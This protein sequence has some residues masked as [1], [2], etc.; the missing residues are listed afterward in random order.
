ML[1]RLVCSRRRLIGSWFSIWLSCPRH[2]CFLAIL[3]ICPWDSL[4][5]SYRITQTSAGSR[6]A[7]ISQNTHCKG[8]YSSSPSCNSHPIH[9]FVISASMKSYSSD[10]SIQNY[11][12][13]T[14]GSV[15]SPLCSF[16]SRSLYPNRQSPLVSSFTQLILPR[17]CCSRS[18][19]PEKT[20]IDRAA[21]IICLFSTAVLSTNSLTTPT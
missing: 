9:S 6:F 18:T 21:S 19:P 16:S 12:S 3:Y 7:M 14:G 5:K 20:T 10:L 2:P 1:A 4:S 15:L 8:S 11:T 13:R 17:I